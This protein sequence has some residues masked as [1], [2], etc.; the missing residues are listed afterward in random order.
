MLLRLMGYCVGF[1]GLAQGFSG[2][3]QG[4]SGLA[5]GLLPYI[6]ILT[7]VPYIITSSRCTAVLCDFPCMYLFWHC[8]AFCGL[9]VDNS[10]ACKAA[11]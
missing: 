6:L 9:I 5:Q 7:A 10:A 8:K 3:A 1:S 2:L 11:F 4:F